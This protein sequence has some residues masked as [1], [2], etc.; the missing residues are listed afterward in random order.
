M[1][2]SISGLPS[3]RLRP[4]PAYDPVGPIEYPGLT[5]ADLAESDRQT[6]ALVVAYNAS[7]QGRYMNGM[8]SAVLLGQEIVRVAR[9]GMEIASAN[10][11]DGQALA[12]EMASDVGDSAARIV[13]ASA[14]AQVASE[15][16][17]PAV[18]P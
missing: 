1:S 5:S 18:A 11:A 7:P 17:A 2:Q 6:A 8:F 16:V 12:H 4:R 3:A 9:A 15:P 10:W 14:K 13:R